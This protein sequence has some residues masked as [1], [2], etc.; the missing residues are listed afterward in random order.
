MRRPTLPEHIARGGEASGQDC[1]DCGRGMTRFEA[2]GGRCAA[3]TE[4][5]D[6]A[7][8]EARARHAAEQRRANA[9]TLMQRAGVPDRYR[10]CSRETWR[11]VFPPKLA[12]WL[13]AGPLHERPNVVLSGPTGTG[14]S[15]LAAALLREHLVAGG[16]GLWLATR[17]LLERLKAEMD[18]PAGDTLETAARTPLLVLDDLGA[19]M[20]AGDRGEWRRDRVAFVLQTRWDEMRPT[21]VTTNAGPAEMR[22]L[23]PR[24]ASRLCSGC[25]VGLSGRDHRF[26]A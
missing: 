5:H 7:E 15:H 26:P 1:P 24:L 2:R 10:G 13:D 20:L 21:V 19:E 14:K 12:A 9:A 3:C 23:E 11:G 17:T 25:V 8:A 6:R 16:A 18:G 4:A 22:A